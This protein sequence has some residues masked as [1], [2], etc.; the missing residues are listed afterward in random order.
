[1]PTIKT[2]GG[3]VLTT[4]GTGLPKVR[5]ECCSPCSL[6]PAFPVLLEPDPEDEEAGFIQWTADQLNL[7][8]MIDFY[9]TPLE[10]SGWGY[11]DTTNGVILEGEKWAVYIYGVRTEQDYLI[12]GGIT[13]FFDNIYMVE[14]DT[15]TVTVTRS[16]CATWNGAFVADGCHSGSVI[17]TLADTGWSVQAVSLT[18]GGG[19]CYGAGAAKYP[20]TPESSPSGSYGGTFTVL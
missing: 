19:P 11:G 13:D 1:M 16:S 9:G 5:C 2:S 4:A 7:P 12:S 20:D 10:R 15:Y 14:W 17:L 18:E 8:G 3:K 6:Y